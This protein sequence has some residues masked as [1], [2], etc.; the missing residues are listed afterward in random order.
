MAYSLVELVFPSPISMEVGKLAGTG[1][2]ISAQS[3]L[4]TGAWSSVPLPQSGAGEEELGQGWHG[5]QLGPA[6]PPSPAA[7]PGGPRKRQLA[8]PDSWR[9]VMLGFLVCLV[10]R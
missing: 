3:S 4:H 8:H 6:E 9:E 1:K 7:T 10:C 5:P 2:L